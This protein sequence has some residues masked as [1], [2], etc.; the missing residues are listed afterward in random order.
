M[1]RSAVDLQG[2]A[3]MPVLHSISANL[4]K[5]DSVWSAARIC[6]Q[7]STLHGAPVP[8]ELGTGASTHQDSARLQAMLRTLVQ[9]KSS[10]SC[11]QRMQPSVGLSC[12]VTPLQPCQPQGHPAW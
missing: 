7:V 2:A 8:K 3:Q 1:G 9:L 4:P 6:R 12:L 5:K 10:S 11:R